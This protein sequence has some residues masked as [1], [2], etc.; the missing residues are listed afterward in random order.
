MTLDE[1]ISE[2]DLTIKS[3]YL[4]DRFFQKWINEAILEIA[5]EFDLPSL[6]HAMKYSVTQA[7]YLY[8]Q[9]EPYLKKLFKASNSDGY[10]VKIYPEIYNITEL[11]PTVSS[12]KAE[13]IAIS[14]GKLAV[15][16]QV[17]DELILWFYRKPKVLEYP[18][19]EVDCIPSIYQSKLIVSKVVIRAL[20]HLVDSA[21]EIP[22][23]AIAYWE[24]EYKRG[25]YGSGFGD[26]GFLNY[27]ISIRGIKRHGGRDPIAYE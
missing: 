14:H 15:Y 13:A 3:A 1:L 25:L 24:G 7:G 8:D 23:D 20:K 16:P 10:S 9:P 2:I 6:K 5:T 22:T 17:N 21:V 19:D 12:G 26:I 18:S 4:S 27:L 11:N